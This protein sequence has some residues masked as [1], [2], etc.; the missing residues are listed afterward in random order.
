MN[1]RIKIIILL[2]LFAVA[3]AGAIGISACVVTPAEAIGAAATTI[4]RARSAQAEQYAPEL[5]Q[6]GEA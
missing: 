4:E 1:L 3:A 2:A 6:K 5:F